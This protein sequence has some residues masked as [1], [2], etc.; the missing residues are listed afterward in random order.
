MG[1]MGQ[2]QQR[3][4]VKLLDTLAGDVQRLSYGGP[5]LWRIPAEAVAG[6]DDVGQPA[7]QRTYQVVQGVVDLATLH[8]VQRL[9]DVR[10]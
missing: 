1:R 3:F 7:G 10:W 4:G 2:P 8:L 6:D 9:S 5:G